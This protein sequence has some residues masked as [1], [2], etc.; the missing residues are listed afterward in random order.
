MAYTPYYSGGWQSGEQGGTPITPA[1]LNNIDNG[2]VTLDTTHN[3]KTYT[4]VT[5]LSLTA[6]SATILS[7][8]NAL[9]DGSAL[10][11]QSSDFATGETPSSGIVE[12]IKWN[13][14]RVYVAFH[15]KEAQN[16]DYRMYEAAT[17]Y[18]NNDVN[19]PSGEWV[20]ELD[21]SILQLQTRTLNNA[22]L[23]NI[24]YNLIGYASDCTATGLSSNF[25]G[26]LIVSSNNSA[27]T[28]RA[29]QILIGLGG[30][31]YYRVYTSAGWQAW[32][33]VTTT[34]YTG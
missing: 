29:S 1:A 18:N 9:G 3:L 30:T 23:D 14:A 27:T 22:N 17:S 21:E 24:N 10:Y 32:R 11:A 15:S 19:A 33:Q 8:Y 28:I 4:S 26:T 12:I 5:Q 25:N 20:M 31:M 6:G 34:A 7:A 16:H 2:I 13:L